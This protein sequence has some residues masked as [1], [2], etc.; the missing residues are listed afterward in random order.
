MRIPNPRERLTEL[1]REQYQLEQVLTE[2]KNAMATHPLKPEIG[3]SYDA[4]HLAAWSEAKRK[5]MARRAHSVN[6]IKEIKAENAEIRAGLSQSPLSKLGM[7]KLIDR[8]VQ[9]EQR[10]NVSK[11]EAHLALSAAIDWLEQE[12]RRMFIEEQVARMQADE[13]GSHEQAQTLSEP[14]LGT[15][16]RELL[17]I[18]Q[19]I[20]QKLERKVAKLEDENQTL[21]KTGTFSFVGANP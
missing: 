8:L 15:S 14:Q 12:E 10:F 7:A 11:D 1:A 2:A 6:R 13:T 16:D 20:I 5:I 19:S 17:E 4:V 9:A 21:R 3:K 18:R